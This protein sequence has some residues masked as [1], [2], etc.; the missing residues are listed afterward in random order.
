[1]IRTGKRFGTAVASI[2]LLGLAACGSDDGG[3]GGGGGGG[4]FEAPD[5]VTVVVHTGPGGGGD[6]LARQVVAMM[7]EEG[8]VEPG[9]W[10]VENREGGGSAVAV[11]Y[12]LEQ[13]GREDLIGIASNIWLVNAM[14]TDG[15]ESSALDLTPLAGIYQDRFGI[16]V[17][18]DSPYETLDDFIEAAEAEPNTLIQ[19]GGS[20]TSNDALVGQTLMRESG[21]T[22]RFLS[23][24]S[25]G[26][27]RTAL[28]RGDG[29]IFL[30][31]T[32][33]LAE[34]VEAGEM[35]LLAIVG[36]QESPLFPD[37]PTTE[38]LGYTEE[39]P[40]QVRYALAPPGISQEAIDWYE[41]KFQELVDSETFAEY[42][43]S[44]DADPVFRTADELGDF[45]VEQEEQH[46]SLF[47][48]TG[49]LVDGYGG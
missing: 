28:L 41:S 43:E 29:D 27:R 40:R 11:N 44:Y 1:M 47:E 35:R 9:A 25:G 34:S 45:L 19:V 32:G 15:V 24:D 33:D 3:G 12:L 26:E 46:V 6:T 17:A 49:Q 36:D 20:N 38:E 7:E 22:W 2:A 16:A 18:A 37:V 8:I 23:F 10:T 30:S 13:E 21:T 48:E 42:I 31:E 14:V 5:Q 39:T 4:D